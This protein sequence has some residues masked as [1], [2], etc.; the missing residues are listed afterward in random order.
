V[1]ETLLARQA[2]ERGG[3]VFE[4]VSVDFSHVAQVVLLDRVRVV[5]VSSKGVVDA[6]LSLDGLLLEVGWEEDGNLVGERVAL[7]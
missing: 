6:K 1:P 4:D 2:L 5:F 3:H 7:V